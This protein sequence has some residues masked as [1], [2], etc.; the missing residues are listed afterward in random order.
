[1]RIV[2]SGTVAGLLL[3][4]S[5]GAQ[6]IL[7][8]DENGWKHGCPIQHVESVDFNSGTIK[9]KSGES[10]TLESSAGI[11]FEET[12]RLRI[13]GAGKPSVV[14]PFAMHGVKAWLDEKG[15]INVDG[16]A[17]DNIEIEI[18]SVYGKTINVISNG[19]VNLNVTSGQPTVEIIGNPIL[20][21]TC[22]NTATLYLYGE[23]ASLSYQ[24]QS[25]LLDMRN[26][27]MISGITP[28]LST[29]NP[30]RMILVNP[31]VKP[32]AALQFSAPRS[33][34][35]NFKTCLLKRHIVTEGVNVIEVLPDRRSFIWIDAA[36]NFKDFANSIDNIRRDLTTAKET[37]F[38]D[39]VVDVRPTTGDVLFKT[40]RV[41]A[42]K[43]LNAWVNGVYGP[44]YRTADF[45][46]MQAFI[47]EG[48]K[49]GL[50]VHAA[51]NTMVAGNKDIGMAFRDSE[52][53]DW[54]TTLNTENGLKNQMDIS[55][56]T[57][58]FFNPLHPQVRE[59]LCGLL[60]DLAAYDGL[61]GIF[62][63]RGRYHNLQSDFSELTR[64]AFE[65]Y[66]GA[67]V[68][69]FPAQIL[70]A[71]AKTYSATQYSKQWLEFR[72]KVMH[73]FMEVARDAVKEV[74]PTLAFGVYVGG[75]YS[76]YYDSGVN[77]ASPN[78]NP[79]TAF[80]WASAKY[81]DYGYADLMDQMLIGA[82]ASPASSYGTGEWTVQGFCSQAMKKIGEACPLV[83]G[84]PDVGNWNTSSVSAEG[85]LAGVTKSV[86][87]AFSVADGYFL[88]DMIHLKQNT[89]KWDAVK[90]GFDLFMQKLPLIN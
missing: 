9:G 66:I 34:D 82:Y 89:K 42:V 29:R 49:L 80:S 4:F 78:Y 83:A 62:L 79:S 48:H 47:D 25:P 63:D 56:E 59:F 54:V 77:W 69:N 67:K 20:N 46:Y 60:R 74:N 50:K 85:E 61:D 16:A 6:T 70:P 37:G 53:R 81:K 3:S 40:N 68:D 27:S 72:A 19:T 17:L 23:P 55:S 75:W 71:G 43:Y 41:D 18:A 35:S 21:I 87:A 7:F 88:F 22:G 39:I 14:N 65:E 2:R 76:S 11:F 8:S 10:H 58:K 32:G 90:D 38:T 57:T 44:V 45:D 24:G 15:A 1:M 31:N 30:S 52:K 86:D 36:A 5:A 12:S 51:I 84:G 64:N 13:F 26:P 28:Y 73:D 33:G